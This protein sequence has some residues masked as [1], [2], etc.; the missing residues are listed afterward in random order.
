METRAPG[1]EEDPVLLAEEPRDE[2]GEAKAKLF[3]IEALK[4]GL[5]TVWSCR[6]ERSFRE[7]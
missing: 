1:A 6:V 7:F 5:K 4:S 3:E 2:H